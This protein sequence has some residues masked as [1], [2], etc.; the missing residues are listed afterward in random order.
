ARRPGAGGRLLPRAPPPR[1]DL[2]H[3]LQVARDRRRPGRVPSR[4]G[5]GRPPRPG[6]AAFLLRVQRAAVALAGRTLRAVPRPVPAAGAEPCG[7]GRLV[8]GAGLVPEAPCAPRPP[9]AAQ[10][11]GGRGAASFPGQEHPAR[12]RL[13]ALDGADA[14]RQAVLVLA[15]PQP[16]HPRAVPPPAGRALPGRTV[17]GPRFCA[18]PGYRRVPGLAVATGPRPVRRAGPGPPPPWTRSP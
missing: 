2:P 7:D 14:D 15:G 18:L 4:P 5:G 13:R 8:R 11:P 9:P 1:R 17:G 10:L 12:G 16:R 6:G 3:V